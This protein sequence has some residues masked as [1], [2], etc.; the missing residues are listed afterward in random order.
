MRSRFDY[1]LL[2]YS[3]TRKSYL[4]IIQSVENKALRIISGALPTSSSESLHCL[5]GELPL[6]ERAKMASLSYATK[7]L[8]LP[9]CFHYNNI[10]SNRFKSLYTRNPNIIPPFYER[11]NRYLESSSLT[12]PNVLPFVSSNSAPW[13]LPPVKHNF[14]LTKYKKET[15][16]HLEIKKAF[17]HL[18]LGFPNADFIYTDASL[19][20]DLNIVGSAVVTPDVTLKFRLPEGSSVFTGELFAIYRALVHILNSCQSRRNHVVCSDSLSSLQCILNIYSES[21]LAQRIQQLL[22][23]LFR[24]KTTVT[25]VY[26][27][28]HVGILGNEKA[29]TAARDAATNLNTK[30]SNIC[31]YSDLK[32]VMKTVVQKEWQERWNANGKHLKIIKPDVSGT[33]IL[34]FHRKDQTVVSRLRLGHSRLTHSYLFSKEP[35]PICDSC[36]TGNSIQHILEECSK[37]GAARRTILNDASLRNCLGNDLD[38]LHRTIE[39]FRTIKLYYSI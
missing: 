4:K 9:T 12:L 24:K 16:L 25:F 7:I 38:N 3:A 8:S 14:S 22:Y 31:V 30:T 18:G 19:N 33:L 23:Q 20:T 35:P 28:S 32:H 6:L 2:A 17:K 27:P 5:L 37:Y 15:T 21:P 39:Y 10:F 34:P 29:D 11:I 26:V 1:G 36:Q 13:I